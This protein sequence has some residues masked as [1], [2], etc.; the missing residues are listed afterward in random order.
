MISVYFKS[1]KINHMKLRVSVVGLIL[2]FTV[3]VIHSQDY[4]LRFAAA[5]PRSA[6]DSVSI[7]NLTRGGTLTI[8]GSQ[9]LHLKGMPAPGEIL[10]HPNP[11]ENYA[12]MEFESPEAGLARIDVYDISGRLVTETGQQLPAGLH[13]FRISGL[14]G[15]V[16]L[17]KVNS[18][19][20][21]SFGKLVGTD[22]SDDQP[23]IR[24]ENSV[25]RSGQAGGQGR[26]AESDISWREGDMMKFTFVSGNR[27]ITLVDIPA[28]SK[29]LIANFISCE[30]ID[31]NNYPVVQ[32]GAQ[33]WMARNLNASHFSDGTA[34]PGVIDAHE[35]AGMNSSAYCWMNNDKY[36]FR[37]PYGKLYN[38]YAANSGILCPSGWHVP[39]ENDWTTLELYLGGRSWAGGKL[40]EDG[41]HW[42]SPNT[43]A[44][45]T[46]EFSMIG[47]G[48][49]DGQGGGFYEL[50]R[51]GY[52][53]SAIE[54]NPTDGRWR[55][56]SYDN[57]QMDLGHSIK[58]TGMSVRCLLDNTPPDP[59][60]GTVTDYEGNTYKTVV[61][62]NQK[63]MAENLR[64]THLANGQAIPEIISAS[65][66]D[67]LYTPGFSWRN[68][69][70]AAYKIPYG[71]LYNWYAVNATS[72]CPSGFHIPSEKDMLTLESFLGGRAI[73]GGKLKEEGLRHWDGPNTGAS[74]STG[75]AML[76]GGYREGSG[77]AGFYE[78]GRGGYLWTSVVE[79]AGSGPW[80]WGFNK[81]YEQT[82]RGSSTLTTGFSVRCLEDD[83]SE[84]IPEVHRSEIMN[85]T[86]ASAEGTGS[87]LASSLFARGICWNTEGEPDTTDNHTEIW[88]NNKSWWFTGKMNGLMP[89][90][91]YFVRAYAVN[92]KGIGYSEQVSFT[93]LP[94]T[95]AEGTLTDID[96]NTYKTVQIGNQ[97]W[98]A[99][100]LKATR[101]ADGT[102]LEKGTRL[103]RPLGKYYYVYDEDPSY[104][105]TYGL[106]YSWFG[107]TNSDNAVHYLK[108]GQGVCPSGWHIPDKEDKDELITFLGGPSV[109][110]GKLKESGF[111]HWISPNT[112]ATNES[113][114]A[115]RGAGILTH[116][117]DMLDGY[118]FT[119]KDKFTAYWTSEIFQGYDFQYPAR[120][121]LN[122]LYNDLN[123]PIDIYCGASVRCLKDRPFT[124]QKDLVAWYPFNGRAND[125]SGKE[126][127]GE[128]H[129]STLTLDRFGRENQA[130]HF[131]GNS[132][133]DARLRY[134]SDLDFNPATSFSIA[135][136]IR[137]QDKE[138]DYVTIIEKGIQNSTEY[139]ISVGSG[140]DPF[141][142]FT[143]S[144][145]REEA[146]LYKPFYL[147]INDGAWHFVVAIV[148]R[149]EKSMKLYQDG[150]LLAE[151]IVDAAREF[152][153]SSDASFKMGTGDLKYFFKGDMD[154]VRVY[155][156]ALQDAE[157]KELYHENGY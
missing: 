136:W 49:R 34:I 91:T 88:F 52:L 15:G 84:G 140:N 114:F 111:E 36:Q 6:V 1:F 30:D 131:D 101:Y 144:R 21:S 5:D 94:D 39:D 73:S 81:D 130:Y 33:V 59:C 8:P 105:D 125:Q 155:R 154:D 29:T 60:P 28:E 118:G 85:I 102:P 123:S 16:Y 24:Y 43:G 152:D 53:W 55:G 116:I 58:T 40:K 10:F 145:D 77:S 124:L 19:G 69:D 12:F 47:G 113:G 67:T 133:I 22:Y 79:N 7:V 61:I 95:L 17:V 37:D 62:G 147:P 41:D 122:Y 120:F 107:A 76:P 128:A 134:P 38:W 71:A 127:G 9:A 64:N 126:N 31:G 151:M 112:D 143:I 98:M 148:N 93:T 89:H 72:L 157:I 50:G 90:T 18:I 63:W 13:T 70:A 141:V 121:G 65:V 27:H 35:W 138:T 150:D 20:Y 23:A 104:K 137:L 57:I 110:A 106:L 96:G 44:K 117:V 14:P 109:A 115:G 66:W 129:G 11:M 56:F 75:F 87:C 82:D 3:S 48:Y 46:Y 92:S 74:N 25:E 42:N 68:N 156:R 132:Y 149:E 54:E 45:D 80:Y 139:R 78:L 146:A 103:T 142:I 153:L 2:M 51:G 4:T 86:S 97:T 108:G 26:A 119:S 99:E 100:N 135:C 83:P 32:I